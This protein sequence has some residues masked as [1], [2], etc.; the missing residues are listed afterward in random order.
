MGHSWSWYSLAAAG[1][2]RL[3]AAMLDAGFRRLAR[4]A[5]Q[6]RTE[7][8]L[9]IHIQVCAAP[10]RHRPGR[11]TDPRPAAAADPLPAGEDE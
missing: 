1:A 2:Y 5:S 4:F 6:A 3:T 10:R 8:C 9:T 7:H 11:T